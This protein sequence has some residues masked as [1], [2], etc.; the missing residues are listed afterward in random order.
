MARALVIISLIALSGCRFLYQEKDQVS[1]FFPGKSVSYAQVRERVFTPKCVSCHGQSGGVSLESYSLVKQNLSLIQS[2]VI[3][4]KIM[5]PRG[6]LPSTDIQLLQAW[7]DAGAPEFSDNTA[8]PTPE[9]KLEAKFSSIRKLIF[10]PKCMACHSTGGLA[11][12]VPFM[13][14]EQ[15]LNS[16]RDI[17]IPKEPDDSGLVIAIER[18]D[19]KRMPPPETGANPL[20]E[21]ERKTIRDWISNGAN[22]D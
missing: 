22:D 12:K 3:T 17:V 21:E 1:L 14:Y 6:A 5:P 10:E 11:E 19:D 2:A 18:E 9:P 20:S 4:Q 16:P 8:T 13:A 15:F 7:I